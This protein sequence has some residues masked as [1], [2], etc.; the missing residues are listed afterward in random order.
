[1]NYIPANC[2]TAIDQINGEYP[3]EGFGLSEC[4]LCGEMTD[5]FLPLEGF[6]PFVCAG[7]GD[8]WRAG[9]DYGRIVAEKKAGEK[10]RK[11]HADY[12]KLATASVSIGIGVLLL[13]LLYASGAFVS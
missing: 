10:L 13:S 9:Y 8:D 1:M 7:C 2:K 6:A 12:N 5:R 4:V 11:A 3:P